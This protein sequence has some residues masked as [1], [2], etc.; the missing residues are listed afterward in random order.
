[1][2][3]ITLEKA[4]AGGRIVSGDTFTMDA[5]LGRRYL[6]ITF[7]SKIQFSALFYGLLLRFN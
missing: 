3:N 1:M 7:E 2:S 4:Y 6:F 5:E